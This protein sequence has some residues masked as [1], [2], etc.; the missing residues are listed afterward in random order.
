MNK[1]IVQSLLNI[2]FLTW[3]FGPVYLMSN[4]IFSEISIKDR[5]SE[6]LDLGSAACKWQ[7]ALSQAFIA[8]PSYSVNIITQYL[9]VY[10][11]EWM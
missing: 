6:P 2:S 3:N 10:S 7:F 9:D 5:L 1:I 11:A 4:D 8:S